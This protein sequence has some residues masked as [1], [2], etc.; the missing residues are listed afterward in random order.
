MA[1]TEFLLCNCPHCA[2]SIEYPA[3]GGGMMVPCPHCHANMSLPVPFTPE[4]EEEAP[5]EPVEKGRSWIGWGIALAVVVL[6]GGVILVWKP[7]K[8]SP[9]RVI[10]KTPSVQTN[11]PPPVQAPPVQV[12]VGLPEGLSVS[13][14][15]MEKAPAGTLV[16]VVGVVKNGSARQRFGVKVELDLFDSKQTKIGVATD[17]QQVIEPQQEWRFRALV[18]DAQAASARVAGLKEDQ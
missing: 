11:A 10:V 14:V 5:V 8:K 4:M 3:E 12:P 13:E 18:L 15:L 2:G 9:G 7:F 16:Y 17:Y 1:D 6:L